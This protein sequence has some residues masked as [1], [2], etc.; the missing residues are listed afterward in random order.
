MRIC[1]FAGSSLGKNPHYKTQA[2]SLGRRLA[3][4]DC[5]IVYGGASIGLMGAL[6]D[7]ALSEGGEVIGVMPEFL[8][9]RE[10]IH[11]DLTALHITQTMHERKAMMAELSDAFMALPGGFGTFDEMFEILTWAQLGLHRKPIG[12]LNIDDYFT[13]LEHFLNHVTHEGFVKPMGRKLLISESSVDNL[14][15]RLIV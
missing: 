4:R 15:D 8:A 6:A 3:K 1:I 14:L 9:Q 12:L 10:I 13:P 5:A 11:A 2:Y 7:G